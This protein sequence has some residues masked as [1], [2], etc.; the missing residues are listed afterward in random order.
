M[1]RRFCIALLGATLI[2]ACD[3]NRVVDVFY[4][5]KGK[6]WEYND[7][8][9]VEVNITDTSSR[10]NV[11]LNLR[12]TGDYEWQNLYLRVKV[13]SPAGDSSVSRVSFALTTPDGHW[14]GSGL[15]DLYEYQVPFKEGIQF[16][17]L[18]I[19]RFELE[20]HMRVNP[21]HGIHDV[22]LRV[23]KIKE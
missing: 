8:K 12:H 16:K 9:T 3:D 13:A 18:G 19:Y 7:V 21:L 23:E 20:Q 15:G 10:C 2:Q 14:L 6:A 17:E 1:T 22:G 11:Y 4:P 5:I